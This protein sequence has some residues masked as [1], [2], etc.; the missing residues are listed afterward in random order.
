MY[1]RTF[2]YDNIIDILEKGNDAS[3]GDEKTDQES[4]SFS[5]DIKNGHLRFR[6][7]KA[8]PNST[9]SLDESMN[10]DI[11]Q[12]K[13]STSLVL[14][15]QIL[16]IGIRI[17]RGAVVIG[18]STTPSILVASYKAANGTVD[19]AKSP[20]SADPYR[21]LYDLALDNFQL[22]MRP[23]INYEKY[24]YGVEAHK[25]DN[26]KTTEDVNQITHMRKY[27]SWFQ[28]QRAAK[29]LHRLYYRLLRKERPEET[30]KR[31]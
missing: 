2:A 4:S 26:I 8:S 30:E 9:S 25:E 27:R 13:G 18:N 10:K 6:N 11:P 15:L 14:L 12:D 22:W 24:R 7:K 20:N 3:S 23:N 21:L 19:V 1:N 5:Y 29:N 31:K 16:P 17:K 28:F